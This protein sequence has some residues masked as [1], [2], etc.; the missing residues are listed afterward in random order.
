MKEEQKV[1][2]L[3][4]IAHPSEHH[5]YCIKG[6]CMWWFKPEKHQKTP[7][8]CIIVKMHTHMWDTWLTIRNVGD[9]IV[10]ELSELE[11]TMKLDHPIKL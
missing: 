3:M 5:A 6:G 7:A 8:G 1:C 2:P 10:E 4:S 9:E 11:E